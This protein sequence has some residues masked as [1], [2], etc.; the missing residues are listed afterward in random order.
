MLETLEE[1]LQLSTVAPTSVNIGAGS[2]LD[3][4]KTQSVP[5]SITLPPVSLTNKVD[6][7]LL[8]DDTGSFTSFASTVESIFS[9]L[10]ASLQSAL[11]GVD[12]GFGVSRFEDYGGPFHTV[13]TEDPQG[14]PFI[15]DQP[16]VTAATAAAAGTDL[17]TLMKNALAATA[18]GFGGDMPEAGIEGLYQLA[19]GA[20]LDGNGNGS[21]LDSGPAGAL[22]S[23]A[24][25][26]GTSGDVPPF[27]SNVGLAAGS[28]G[29][30]GWRPDAEHIV[31]LA[32][33]TQPVAAFSTSPIPATV[34]GLGGATVPSTAFEST[35]K[36]FSGFDST[37]V[38]GTGNGP[39][40]GRGAAGR[41]DRPGDRD[42]PEQAGNPRDRHGSRCGADEQHGRGREAQHLPVRDWQ[43]DGSRR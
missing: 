2:T 29:G 10:V 12:F 16:I 40:P 41:R 34:S 9:N 42:C 7:A 21:K 28:L 20:G 30:I 31:L 38:D 5:L 22:T 39:Q 6:I 37:A 33:D 35:A 32:T 27:S 4:T 23:T 18:P 3:L 36:R 43:A 19:T 26:P 24:V 13:S 1:R 17:N 8:L 15:L 25:H 11:P 14:R